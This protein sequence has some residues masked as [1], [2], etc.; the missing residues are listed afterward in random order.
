MQIGEG[1]ISL[2]RAF[3]IVGAQTVLASHWNVNDNATSQLMTEFIRRWRSGEPRAK[4]WREAMAELE[5]FIE[6][7][8]E[9]VH[10]LPT[11]LRDRYEQ[12][13]WTLASSGIERLWR[14]PVGLAVRRH[15]AERG[16]HR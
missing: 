16:Q 6:I 14:L 1:L 10:R 8:G 9:A 7:I 11:E 4:A 3:R 15:V 2:R 13:G 12:A 5:R